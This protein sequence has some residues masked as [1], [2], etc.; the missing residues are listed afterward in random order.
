MVLLDEIEKAHTEVFDILLQ[1]LDD[2]RLTD[3]QGRTVDFTNVVLVMTSNLAGDPIDH[4]RPEFVN[5]IDE[6]VR[7]RAL[8]PSDLVPIIDIQLTHLRHRLGQ[9]SHRARGHRRRQ[10]AHR[11]GGLRPCV[12]GPAY[13]A[14]DPGSRSTG[15]QRPPRGEDRRR[16]SSWSS[17]RPPMDCHGEP[18]CPS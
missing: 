18:R 15:W 3:G 8:T 4:F 10:G 14:G 16:L 17:M 1:V 2:G 7:F 5:R 11:R 6:I 9:P 12:R 13:E